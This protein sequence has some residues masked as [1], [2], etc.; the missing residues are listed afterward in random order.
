MDLYLPFP[1]EKSNQVSMTRVIEAFEIFRSAHRKMFKKHGL[2]HVYLPVEHLPQYLDYI[3]EVTEEVIDDPEVSTKI[4]AEIVYDNAAQIVREAMAEPR[5][6]HNIEVGQQYVKTVVRFVTEMPEA[7]E[8]LAEMMV[9]DYSVY[10]HSVNVCLLN[11]AFAHFLGLPNDK[12]ND[13]GLGGLLHDVGKNKI[14]E[15]ILKKPAKLDQE[16][17][18]L[19]KSHPA[20][21]F[22]LLRKS[23]RL[24]PDTLRMI[25]QHHENFDGTGYPRG[26][27]HEQISTPSRIIRLIDAYDAIT[28]QRCYK[29]AVPPF[30]AIKVMLREMSGQIWSPLFEPFIV[31]LG[32]I[33]GG[34]FKSRRINAGETVVRLAGYGRERGTIHARPPGGR[35]NPV[36]PGPIHGSDVN[37]TRLRAGGGGPA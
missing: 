31:F 4:K 7:I 35:S 10:T 21:G 2:S 27:K 20:S 18:E 11:A 14:P 25:Y 16:E 26:L 19:I 17:W 1:V 23:V 5:L 36:G 9:I 12:V 15:T 28:A 37:R 22:R 29:A 6:G 30:K 8:C 24:A 13:I 32:Q 34:A 33:A 3:K